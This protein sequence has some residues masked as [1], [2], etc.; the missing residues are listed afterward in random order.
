MFRVGTATEESSR[1]VTSPV[2]KGLIRQTIEKLAKKATKTK[3]L[4]V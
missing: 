2:S 3:V 1:G 4:L